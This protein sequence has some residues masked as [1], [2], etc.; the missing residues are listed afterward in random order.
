[1]LK[2]EPALSVVVPFSQKALLPVM[3][4]LKEVLS[5]IATLPDPAHPLLSI[6]STEYVPGEE[7][8]MVWLVELLLHV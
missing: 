6:I 2:P 8:V 3:T 4:G 1:M 5:V 7:T